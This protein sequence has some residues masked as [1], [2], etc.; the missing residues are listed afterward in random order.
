MRQSIPIDKRLDLH[1]PACPMPHKIINITTVQY[2]LQAPLKHLCSIQELSLLVDLY[3]I[4]DHRS[5]GARARF[6]SAL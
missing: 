4:G 5:G 6:W 1:A 2:Y 3:F